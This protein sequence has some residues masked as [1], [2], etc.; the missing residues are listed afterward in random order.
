MTM[1]NI[2]EAKKHLEELIEKAMNVEEIVIAHAGEPKVRLVPVKPD[3]NNWF[4]MDEGKIRI[5]DDFDSFNG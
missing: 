2:G 1:V 5:A 3:V 4:G